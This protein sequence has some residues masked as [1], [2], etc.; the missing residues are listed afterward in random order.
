MILRA[1]TNGAASGDQTLT[2]PS[3]IIGGVLISADGTNNATVV[4]RREDSSGK[5]I[6]H[7]VSKIPLWL[8]GPFSLEGS[9]NA[10]VSVS[11]TGALGQFYE[12]VE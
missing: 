9:Q 1:L 11:G 5:P 12:W 10:F 4:V 3:R 7:V 8:T 6:I 2:G